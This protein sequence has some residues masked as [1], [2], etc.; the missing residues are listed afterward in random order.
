MRLAVAGVLA[1]LTLSGEA[2]AYYDVADDLFGP[3]SQFTPRV[4]DQHIE[5]EATGDEF[6]RRLDL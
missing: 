5:D 4:V 2:Q 3:Q 1:L 6:K